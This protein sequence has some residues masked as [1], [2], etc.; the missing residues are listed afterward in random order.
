MADHYVYHHQN[1]DRK[2]SRVY[3]NPNF[4]RSDNV[5]SSSNNMYLNPKFSQGA[6][7]LY[8]HNIQKHKEQASKARIHVNPNFIR[9]TNVVY[10]I[11]TKGP[12]QPIPSSSNYT[13][14]KQKNE[15]ATIQNQVPLSHVTKSRY[16]L[17]RQKENGLTKTPISRPLTTTVRVN[18]YK[19][20]SLNAVKNNLATIKPTNSTM[21]ASL[22]QTE[23]QSEK[24]QT[25][26]KQNNNTRFQFVKPTT[27][28]VLN[29]SQKKLVVIRRYSY[30]NKSIQKTA[31][32]KINIKQV[33]KKNNIPCPLFKKY[34]KCLRKVR[35]SC[36][37]LHDK[38][39]V[40]ICR[41]FLIGIC[42]DG[43]C[44]LSHDLTDKKMPTCYFYLQGACTKDNCP[45]LHVKLNEKTKACQDFLRGYCEKGDKCLF[46]HLSVCRDVA[47]KKVSF[48][49]QLTNSP[50]SKISS[51]VKL[52]GRKKSLV[53]LSHH[54]N[55]YVQ[56]HHADEQRYF[57]ETVEI[58]SSGDN[59]NMIKPSR[60]K[61]G[62]LPSFIQI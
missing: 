6:P 15:E 7:N 17:V 29:Q 5:S 18:K 3:I 13:C 20:V 60:I 24:Y 44:L 38:K 2:N 49:K 28:T 57:K 45:Y 58:K 35:G 50:A 26:R 34:G 51:V 19:S 12:T 31:P 36:E 30:H 32:K 56:D 53:M 52:K 55:A 41:K 43:D 47:S 40:S 42:H 61:L 62:I 46:R 1:S 54:G 27:S 37:Y 39:H 59:S 10:P 23:S 25:G 21:S 14:K 16:C 48:K 11:V 8:P 9:N 4:N 22:S 33:L